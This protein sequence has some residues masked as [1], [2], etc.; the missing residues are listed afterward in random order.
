MSTAIVDFPQAREIYVTNYY[1]APHYHQIY[2]KP[3]RAIRFRLD[4]FY[5]RK[6]ESISV[7]KLT[8]KFQIYTNIPVKNRINNISN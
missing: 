7:Q 5:W 8:A 1:N 6:S 4:I 2:I 3:E